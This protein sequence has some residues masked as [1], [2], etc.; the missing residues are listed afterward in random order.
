MFTDAKRVQLAQCNACTLF[1][2][3]F[4]RGTDWFIHLSFLHLHWKF[5]TALSVFKFY[6]QIPHVQKFIL[7][8]YR[9]S[10]IFFL[11]DLHTPKF[12][13]CLLKIMFVFDC[14]FKE[15]WKHPQENQLENWHSA[16]WRLCCLFLCSQ[17]CY[18]A[19]QIC[20]SWGCQ[21]TKSSLLFLRQDPYAELSPGISNVMLVYVM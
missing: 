18:F 21:R 7:V 3:S 8:V 15:C 4:F 16:V 17:K 11:I 13:V 5:H 10:S 6:Y 19:K 2:G 1:P 14:G 20:D 12:Y 9:S